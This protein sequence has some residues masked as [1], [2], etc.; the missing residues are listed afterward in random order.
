MPEQQIHMLQQQICHHQDEIQ[1]LQTQAS[2]EYSMG[3]THG[4]SC[5]FEE[6][7][8]MSLGHGPVT[9]PGNP[10]THEHHEPHEPHNHHE[11]WECCGN[12][13]A[14]N[15]NE[16]EVEDLQCTICES[17]HEVWPTRPAETPGAGPSCDPSCSAP[18]Q[19]SSSRSQ[20]HVMPA[21][22]ATPEYHDYKVAVI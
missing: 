8:S 18:H 13:K 9:N 10:S 3:F 16:A 14:C 15:L 2:Q 12:R 21:T 11:D 20:A 22:N 19:A 1:T 6:A 5:S 4:R 7:M 17:H